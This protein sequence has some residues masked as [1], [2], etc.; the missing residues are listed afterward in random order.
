ML[1]QVGRHTVLSRQC[2]WKKT[3]GLFKPL[4]R[5]SAAK[6]Q[7]TTSGVPESLAPQAGDAEL[8]VGAFEKIERQT[9]TRDFQTIAD[10]CHV[11]EDVERRRRIERVESVDAVESGGE[12]FDFLAKLEHHRVAL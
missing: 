4:V 3:E 7:E 5:L 1:F 12:Q 9:V 6:P 2:L 8:F 10:G 11:W